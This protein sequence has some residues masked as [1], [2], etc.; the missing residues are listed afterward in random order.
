MWFAGI[1]WADRHHEVVVLN[2]QGHQ[3]GALRV[4]HSAAGPEQLTAFLRGFPSTEEERPETAETAELFWQSTG[5]VVCVQDDAWSPDRCA[6]GSWSG[7][8]SRQPHHGGA[9]ASPA[10]VK[11]DALDAFLLARKG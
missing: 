4:D 11:T 1:D 8:L 5:Q 6:F 7:G 3:V 2:E 9:S 10:G